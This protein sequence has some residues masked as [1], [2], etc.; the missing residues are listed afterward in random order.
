[1]TPLLLAV[2]LGAAEAKDF[3]DRGVFD[4]VAV[5]GRP[6]PGS[7]FHELRF[8]AVANGGVESLCHEVF[9][10]TR[11]QPG[12]FVV[13]RQV[14]RKAPDELLTY[15]RV[16]PPL[17]SPRD[18]LL[19]RWRTRPTAGVCRIDFTSVDD[20]PEREGSVRLKRLF[21]SFIFQLQPDG[22]VRIEHRVHMD[23]G[24][25]LT[26]ALVEPTQQQMGVAWMR[27]LLQAR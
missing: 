24:G 7:A 5:S 17:V 6:V 14:V 21:G 8:V 19:R 27:R 9:R 22:K 10:V 23:P 18:Y 3:S 25:Y 1:M 20:A 12:E 15:E 11:P 16:A 13:S 26:P 4:G 2:L